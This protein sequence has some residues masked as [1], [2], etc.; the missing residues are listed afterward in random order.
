MQG[1]FLVIVPKLSY[2]ILTDNGET[3]SGLCETSTHASSFSHLL[4][5]SVKSAMFSLAV[6][7][8]GSS[9]DGGGFGNEI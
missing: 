5:R 8:F 1:R 6:L 4:M 2:S 7:L 9:Y 3:Q